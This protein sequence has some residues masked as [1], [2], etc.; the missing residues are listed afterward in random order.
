MLFS[1]RVQ[2]GDHLSSERRHDEVGVPTKGLTVLF[3]ACAAVQ[4]MLM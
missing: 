2:T 4:G 3:V 1:H